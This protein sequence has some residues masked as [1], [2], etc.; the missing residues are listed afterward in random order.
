M[1][2]Y[3]KCPE[4]M[5]PGAHVLRAGRMYVRHLQCDLR[6][7]PMSIMEA[8][9]TLSITA[10]T[11]VS[12]NGYGPGRVVMD[13]GLKYGVATSIR[14]EAGKSR[15]RIPIGKSW[16][17]GELLSGLVGMLGCEI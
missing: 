15:A 1:T 4:G 13:S 8:S 14:F 6:G 3:L 12:R 9:N 11:P 2:A 5:N 10:L 7:S 16:N 17:Y